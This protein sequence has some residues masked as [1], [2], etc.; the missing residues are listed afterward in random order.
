[1]P[2]VSLSLS[3]IPAAVYRSDPAGRLWWREPEGLARGLGARL[4]APWALRWA[5][6]GLCASLGRPPRQP[7]AARQRASQAESGLVS[8]FSLSLSLLVFF[9][10]FPSLFLFLFLFLSSLFSLP[11]SLSLSRGPYIRHRAPIWA[12]A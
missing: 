3:C 7:A 8:E 4:G 10:L 1:M 2:Q 6:V 12:K 9:F 5:R 11:L